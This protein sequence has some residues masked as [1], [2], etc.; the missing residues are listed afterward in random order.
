M[1]F[2]RIIVPNSQIKTIRGWKSFEFD[3]QKY[4]L[5]MMEIDDKSWQLQFTGALRALDPMGW[6]ISAKNN[7]RFILENRQ[8]TW[9]NED[10]AKLYSFF[11]TMGRSVDSKSYFDICSIVG[12]PSSYIKSMFKTVSQDAMP[13]KSFMAEASGTITI[14]RP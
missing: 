7:I 9:D 6:A 8:T 13:A 2:E 1:D 5:G 4:I 12:S 14:R 10:Q 11:K 3:G